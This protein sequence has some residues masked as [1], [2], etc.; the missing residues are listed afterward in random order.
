M[1]N[2]YTIKI[3]RLFTV[4]RNAYE[5][6]RNGWLNDTRNIVMYYRVSSCYQGGTLFIFHRRL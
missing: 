5:V 2:V 3:S 4:K 1:Y 6:C